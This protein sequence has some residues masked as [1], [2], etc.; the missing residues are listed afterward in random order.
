MR[1]IKDLKLHVVIFHI[2]YNHLITQFDKLN[3]TLTV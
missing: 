3:L 1:K 2:F